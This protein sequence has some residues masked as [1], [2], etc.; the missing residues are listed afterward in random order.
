MYFRLPLLLAASIA[1]I[2][3]MALPL[4]ASDNPPSQVQIFQK[5]AGEIRPIEVQS[6]DT[7]IALSARHGV[8]VENIMRDNGITDPRA[9]MPGQTL[10][11]D[12]RRII[13]SLTDNGFVADIPAAM[14]Y[15]FEAGR[16]TSRHPA[17]F[18]SPSKPTPTGTVPIS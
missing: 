13:P 1:A 11:L 9:I 12:T 8:R 5:V 3:T 7:L 14:I 2:S 4:W 15:R 18:G 10:K 6:G 16:L 17:G